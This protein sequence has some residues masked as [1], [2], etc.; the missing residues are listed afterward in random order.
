M[1]LAMMSL[2]STESLEEVVKVVHGH[3][4][5]SHPNQYHLHLGKMAGDLAGIT[6]LM[7]A[8][9]GGLQYLQY[10]T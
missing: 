6:D 9:N 10:N 1:V 4:T 3:H 5:H 2:A 7:R 8:V